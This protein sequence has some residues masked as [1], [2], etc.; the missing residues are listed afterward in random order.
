MSV[1]VLGVSVRVFPDET[2]IGIDRLSRADGPPSVSGP[3]PVKS[4]SRI[5]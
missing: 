2:N 4:L 3:H 1:I 5:S